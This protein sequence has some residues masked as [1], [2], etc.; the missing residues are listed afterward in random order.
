ML[1]FYQKSTDADLYPV[2][3]S[4][5]TAEMMRGSTSQKAE[6]GTKAVQKALPD[7]KVGFIFFLLTGAHGSDWLPHR[8]G[9]LLI[10]GQAAMTLTE[11][12]KPDGAL[13]FSKC[14]FCP[15]QTS[16]SRK[17]KPVTITFSSI[18]VTPHF[19]SCYGFLQNHTS[20]YRQKVFTR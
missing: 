15:N 18:V 16:V 8:G 14:L 19:P 12:P 5:T 11:R 1:F 10:S 6:L 7:L 2:Q 20:K 3:Q 13:C 4:P 17:D 9:R